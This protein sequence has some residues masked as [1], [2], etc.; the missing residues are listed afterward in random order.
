MVPLETISKHLSPGAPWGK[1]NPH[2]Q[3]M[4]RTLDWLF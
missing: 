4:L 1:K 2:F 3:V